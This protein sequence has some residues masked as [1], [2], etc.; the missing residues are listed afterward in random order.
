MNYKTSD[1]ITEPGIYYTHYL[2]DTSKISDEEKIEYEFLKVYN[3]YDL[4]FSHTLENELVIRTFHGYEE[5]G[6]YSY[7]CLSKGI[8]K[9]L[10]YG[11]LKDKIKPELKVSEADIKRLKTK[12]DVQKTVKDIIK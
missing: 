9:M 11:P 5:M 6:T 12:L 7:T 4:P 3:S 2:W 1:E 8:K 10:F